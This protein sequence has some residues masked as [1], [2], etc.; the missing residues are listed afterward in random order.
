MRLEDID[1]WWIVGG[2]V[3]AH[4]VIAGFVVAIL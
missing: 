2:L 4:A 3:L 1:P